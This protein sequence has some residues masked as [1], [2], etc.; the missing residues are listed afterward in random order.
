MMRNDLF[1]PIKIVSIL[2]I[3]FLALLC[4]A[5]VRNQSPVQQSQMN[6]DSLSHSIGLLTL[7]A[8]Q[9]YKNQQ[10]DSAAYYYHLVAQ[11]T[12]R[13]LFGNQLYFKAA[14]SFFRMNNLDRALQYFK[15]ILKENPDFI[16]KDYVAYFIA[17][18]LFRKNQNEIA[19]RSL[20]KTYKESRSPYLKTLIAWSVVLHTNDPDKKLSYLNRIRL[21]YLAD[22]V[23]NFVELKLNLL[24]SRHFPEYKKYLFHVL[25][26]DFRKQ[27]EDSL[28]KRIQKMY[29]QISIE[30]RIKVLDILSRKNENLYFDDWYLRITSGAELTVKNRTR[31][32]LIKSLLLYKNRKYT[33]AYKLLT[34]L[35]DR[36]LSKEERANKYLHV[37]RCQARLGF[38][39][40]AIRAYYRFQKK[41]PHHKLAPDALW[42]IA[43]TY[44]QRKDFNNAKRFL[45]LLSRKYRKEGTEAKFRLI[46]M[47]IL[48]GN[49]QEA[50]VNLQKIEKKLDY[51]NYIRALYWERYIF[52]QFGDMQA[53][54]RIA[55]ELIQDPFQNIYSLRLFFTRKSDSLDYYLNSV[56][57]SN[58]NFSDLSPA[59]SKK[60]DRVLLVENLLGK[61]F[62][63]YE[64]QHIRRI[65]YS[66]ETELILLADLNEKLGNYGFA[67][68][69]LRDLYYA[70]Y[71][72]KPWHQKLHI[73]KRLYPLYYEQLVQKYCQQFDVDP[74]LVFGLMKRESMFRKDVKSYANAYGLLQILPSTAHR[75]NK[76]L[77]NI[78]YRDPIDLFKPEVNIPLGVYY[79]YK[80]LK[81]FNNHYPSVIA[82]YNAGEHRVKRWRERYKTDNDML[83]I[84]LIP[85]EQTRKYV[86][87]VLYYYFAYQWFYNP[88]GEI[89]FNLS[90]Y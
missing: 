48:H 30:E 4:S 47:D 46:F 38:T 81:D 2:A 32:D 37:A 72:S 13:N 85:I 1:N 11:S 42:W 77:K 50:L 86:K 18:I 59:F 58:I 31:V 26:L 55:N 27:Y 75:L 73:I 8:D 80:L 44:E 60:I 74:L 51:D 21:K 20:E 40:D 56:S 23:E 61:N 45:N 25:T 7:K 43:L 57:S 76:K 6:I 17:Q 82:S 14:Y 64:I 34:R 24:Q 87:Y 52:L 5:P 15:S 65:P 54:D 90:I 88:D 33:S 36:Y 9:F 89:H 12:R 19:I 69:L 67:Y 53:A 49:L 79:I 63:R 16:L 10:Y 84:E 71:I 35:K 83:F 28:Y 41:F 3:G 62:A 22:Q 78:P 66:H 68:S 29:D 70:R 39:N